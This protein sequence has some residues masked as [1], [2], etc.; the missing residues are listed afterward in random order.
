MDLTETLNRWHRDPPQF[1][2]KELNGFLAVQ[3]AGGQIGAMIPVQNQGVGHMAGSCLSDF[4][5][6]ADVE[7]KKGKHD[8][9]R[10]GRDAENNE[11]EGR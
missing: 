4:H 3:D 11:S 9:S 1:R 7:S 2:I 10:Q 5:N 8:A 6:L